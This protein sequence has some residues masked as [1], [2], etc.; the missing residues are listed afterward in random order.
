MAEDITF[1]AIELDPGRR[2]TSRR[3]LVLDLVTLR[4]ATLFLIPGASDVVVS[5]VLDGIDK[6][7]RVTV[8]L[9]VGQASLTP[10][11]VIAIISADTFPGEL[12]AFVGTPLRVACCTYEGRVL[13]A[14]SPTFVPSPPRSPEDSASNLLWGLPIWAIVIIF[15]SGGTLMLCILLVLIYCLLRRRRQQRD[16]ETGIKAAPGRSQV[17]KKYSFQATPDTVGGYGPSPTVVEPSSRAAEKR[18]VARAA[19]SE[20]GPSSQVCAGAP[21]SVEPSLLVASRRLPSLENSI[22]P[23]G[24][25]R[26]SPG[27]LRPENSTNP[28]SSQE[29]SEA[30]QAAL[31]HVRLTELGDSSQPNNEV[32]DRAMEKLDV[33]CRSSAWATTKRNLAMALKARTLPESDMSLE[34]HQLFH[35]LSSPAVGFREFT[36]QEAEAVVHA[37]DANG[38]G[39]IN[40][41]QLDETVNEFRQQ[42]ELSRRKL[43]ATPHTGPSLAARVSRNTSPR[44]GSTSHASPALVHALESGRSSDH[45]QSTEPARLRPS[46]RRGRAIVGDSSTD[47]G[48][49][50]V[51]ARA[52]LSSAPAAR[53]SRCL[54]SVHAMEV[55]RESASPPRTLPAIHAPPETIRSRGRESNV[56]PL[57]SESNAESSTPGSSQLYRPQRPSGSQLEPWRL[58][59]V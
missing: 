34:A 1:R 2:L 35:V 21:E 51:G 27:S 50:S 4:N 58:Y 38:S 6:I 10:E 5:Q 18:P 43:A 54:V 15:A 56:F 48:S 3:R 16:D 40:I 17:T 8:V 52:N 33:F 41:R 44:M 11:G 36:Q 23:N 39:V 31:W 47:A 49:P 22:R 12:S 20:A 55:S 32:L 28:S 7:T 37:L 24:P 57:S 9:I 59:K 53:T 46:P 25:Q 29:E 14:P 13:A 26:S 19:G 42:R 30:P 45:N